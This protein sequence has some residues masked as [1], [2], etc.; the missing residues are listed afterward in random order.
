[1]KSN[2]GRVH[3]TASE[4]A[5]DTG[6]MWQKKAMLQ[7]KEIRKRKE[8]L[9]LVMLV[10]SVASRVVALAPHHTHTTTHNS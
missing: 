10:E 5:A 4:T 9:E 6:D 7:I 8:S 3:K 1:M 2:F